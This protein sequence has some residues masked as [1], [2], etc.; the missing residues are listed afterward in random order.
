MAFIGNGDRLLT[1]TLGGD[2][3]QLRMWDIRGGGEEL[4]L[5]T[6]GVRPEAAKGIVVSPAGDRF[7]TVPY[8]PASPCRLWDAGT[9]RMVAELSEP[10][11]ITSSTDNPLPSQAAFSADGTRLA[12]AGRG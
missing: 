12:V 5:D 7:V 2:W 6:G 10:T 9:G 8:Y 1:G 4:R 11:G 3:P